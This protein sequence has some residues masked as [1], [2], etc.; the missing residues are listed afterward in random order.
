MKYTEVVKLSQ[1]F[2]I[3]VYV[4]IHY[5]LKCSWQTTS[6]FTFA[7]PLE[8]KMS[9]DNAI[10]ATVFCVLLTLLAIG[11]FIVIG[12]LVARLRGIKV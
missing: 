2:V 8:N 9:C 3:Y 10:A 5:Y 1:C 12:V 11:E 6:Q 7:K 4:Y